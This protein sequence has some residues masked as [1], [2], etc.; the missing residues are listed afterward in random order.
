[1][2]V[3]IGPSVA[4]LLNILRYWAFAFLKYFNLK[5]SYFSC[6]AIVFLWHDFCTN[7]AIVIML[8]NYKLHFFITQSFISSLNQKSNT[9]SL[10]A[11]DGLG[12]SFEPWSFKKAAILAKYTTSEKLSITTS[13][14]S[15]SD[16]ER[17]LWTAL[18]IWCLGAHPRYSLVVDED[19]NKNKNK[20]KNSLLSKYIEIHWKLLFSAHKKPTK[21]HI[22]NQPNKQTAHL[23]AFS[24]IFPLSLIL[25]FIPCP[26]TLLFFF[27]CNPKYLE[28]FVF[29]I[30]SSCS[31]HTIYSLFE[32]S[33]ELEWH[34]FLSFQ[35]RKKNGNDWSESHSYVLRLIKEMIFYGLSFALLLKELFFFLSCDK[36]S[37]PGPD[38]N[39]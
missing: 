18:L 36:N 4:K 34:I 20:N 24:S 29:I 31:I 12:D 8:C 27:Q 22:R 7:L 9:D 16:Q 39:S 23:A 35:I 30:D 21:Q 33:I 37:E 5:Y 11:D 26:D 2:R 17:G 19:V 6:P 28:T 13:F 1:M 25:K 32:D 38:R 3:D 15:T 14:L 10:D